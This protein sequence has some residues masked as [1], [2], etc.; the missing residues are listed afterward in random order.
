[1]DSSSLVID[2]GRESNG[3][4]D[5]TCLT[6][7]RSVA[8]GTTL[9]RWPG[10]LQTSVVNFGGKRGHAEQGKTG[11]MFSSCKVEGKCEVSSGLVQKLISS[12]GGTKNEVRDFGRCL[13]RFLID[14]G[15]PE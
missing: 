3:I 13:R 11:M 10:A 8:E 1:M 5:S 7:R 14:L 2:R 15:F 4:D 9:Q 12:E 6:P